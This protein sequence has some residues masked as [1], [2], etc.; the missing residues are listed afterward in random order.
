VSAIAANKTTVRNFFDTV[1]NQRQ[2]NQLPNFV[3]EDGTCGGSSFRDMAVDP[4]PTLQAMGAGRVVPPATGA[5]GAPI[6][7]G[8]PE[9][10]AAKSSSPPIAGAAAAPSTGNPDVDS[11][12][13]FTEHVLQA[14]PDMKVE[15]KS[16]VAEGDQVVVRWTATGTHRG[17]FLGTPATGRTVPMT[18]VD[19]FTLKDG[20][21][22]GVVSHPDSAGVLHALGHLPDTPL[23]RSLGL[24][25]R[26][27]P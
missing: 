6:A 1:V 21:I 2:V 18:N 20:K 26:S 13:D 9:A 19:I 16:I 4:D 17:T 24:G 11:F 5:A 14:F 22:V 27:Q 3:A 10:T 7:G 23:A 8:A 25:V 15:I 12:R